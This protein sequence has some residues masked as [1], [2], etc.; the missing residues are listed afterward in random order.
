MAAD[1]VSG[2]VRVWWWC[3]EVE[4]KEKREEESREPGIFWEGSGGGRQAVRLVAAGFGI[5]GGE[6]GESRM[7]EIGR[8]HRAKA[9]DLG[10]RRGPVKMTTG[11][12]VHR[13]VH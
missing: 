9:R 10:G 4:K 7:S 11:G 1:S 8:G 6:E 13:P 2:G 5:G 12:S 3:V